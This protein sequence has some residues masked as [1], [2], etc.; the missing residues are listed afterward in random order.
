MMKQETDWACDIEAA[1]T[2][3]P[4]SSVC[5]SNVATRFDGIDRLMTQGEKTRRA[6]EAPP[7]A[8]EAY[9]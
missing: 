5:R 9:A 1:S 8:A 2:R 7:E 6:I 4:L 3:R